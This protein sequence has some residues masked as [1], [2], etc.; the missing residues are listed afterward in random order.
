[1][2]FSEDVMN[3]NNDT[4]FLGGNSEIERKDKVKADIYD[5]IEVFVSALAIVVIMLSFVLRIAT[6]KGHSMERTLSDSQVVVM[7]NM[8]YTPAQGDIIVIQQNGGYFETPIVKRVIA[9][10]GQT[11]S[12]D[13]EKWEVKVDGNV[14]DESSYVYFRNTSMDVEEYYSVYDAY[15]DTNGVMTVPEGYLFVMGDNRNE[16]SD[17]RSIYVGFVRESE[18]LGKV[19]FRMFPI[20]KIGAVKSAGN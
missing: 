10:G 3:G 17:S 12:I 14:V 1:M 2:I 19:I 4:E 15:L 18:V 5:W 8:F 6:V 20:N 11:L 13:F 9:T 7:S 16:S